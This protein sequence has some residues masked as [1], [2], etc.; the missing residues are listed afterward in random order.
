MSDEPK[1]LTPREIADRERLSIDSV[2]RA[3]RNKR[4]SG[5]KVGSRGDWRVPYRQYQLWVEA[6]A[7]TQP[8]KPEKPEKPE[9]PTKLPAKPTTP[10]EE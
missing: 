7:P 4:L 5:H 2:K 6:G 1:P 8:E 10:A 9:T 3:L